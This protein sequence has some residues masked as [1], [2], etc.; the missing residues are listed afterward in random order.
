MA[1]DNNNEYLK[2]LEKGKIK[3]VTRYADITPI[4]KVIIRTILNIKKEFLVYSINSLFEKKFKYSLVPEKFSK[5]IK[6]TG[7]NKIREITIADNLMD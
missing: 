2:K 5:I 3:K 1:K 4:T 6:N 7:A